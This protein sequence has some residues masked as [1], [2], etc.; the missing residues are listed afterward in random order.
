MS[1]SE[2]YSWQF[3]ASAVTMHWEDN[4]TR[5]IKWSSK[6]SIIIIQKTKFS[7]LTVIYKEPNC[8]TVLQLSLG[9]NETENK[10]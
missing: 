4:K 6:N 5:L 3:L 7:T 9:A 2:Q 1:I 8:K 10:W